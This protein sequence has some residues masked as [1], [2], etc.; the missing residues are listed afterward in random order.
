MSDT[1]DANNPIP[2]ELV[3]LV[4]KV[5]QRGKVVFS[6]A[7]MVHEA[8]RYGKSLT[9]G[10]M[11]MAKMMVD[12]KGIEEPRD[13]GSDK[14]KD[15][16]RPAGYAIGFAKAQEN[17]ETLDRNLFDKGM[18]VFTSTVENN[19]KTAFVGVDKEGAFLIQA[20]PKSEGDGF[21]KLMR[22]KI[23]QVGDQEENF[24]VKT[25]T[26]DEAN[27]RL[28]NSD[29]VSVV[30]L[31]PESMPQAIKLASEESLKAPFISS[32]DARLT[33]ERLNKK[34]ES[35]VATKATVKLSEVDF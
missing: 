27:A 14:L 16:A 1:V 3:N 10:Q 21:L 2:Q 7:D 8:I 19:D 25:G 29:Y 5:E 15:K 31:E 30:P 32:E 35:V 6:K 18:M 28:W 26:G 20:G 4:P 33:S 17:N 12:L 9:E 13:L 23:D 24:I 11:T 34:N 22:D